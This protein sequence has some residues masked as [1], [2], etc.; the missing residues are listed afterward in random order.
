MENKTYIID[1]NGSK[2]SVTTHEVLAFY[3][4]RHSLAEEEIGRYAARYVAQMK[5][6]RS[7]GGYLNKSLVERLIDEERLMKKGESDGF[8]LQLTFDWYVVVKKEGNEYLPFKYSLE[9]WCLDNVQ[10]F[11]RRYVTLSDAV[12]HCLNSFNENGA[13]KNRY[14]SIEWYLKEGAGVICSICGNAH[15]KCAAVADPNTKEFF[16]FGCEAFLDGLC[17]NCHDVILTNP[18]EVQSDID[19]MY[20]EHLANK[21]SEPLFAYCQIVR[22]DNYD[23]L[24]GQFIRL[25]GNAIDKSDKRQIASCCGIEELKTMTVPADDR[26][27]TVV[28][29]QCLSTDRF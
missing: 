16:D 18:K 3:G 21:K 15:V 11:S 13:I 10:T 8:K 25:D 19:R 4:Q 2:I 1:V 5:Y 28:E 23:G 12:L 26:C 14:D 22:T 29:C 7:H 6:H 24:E 9:A 17:E 20:Q 27:F